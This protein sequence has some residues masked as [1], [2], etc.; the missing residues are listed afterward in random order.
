MTEKRKLYY[1][2][3]DARHDNTFVIVECG[4]VVFRGTLSE[5]RD[6]MDRMENEERTNER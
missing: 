1:D 2:T 3:D 4:D 6:E 5:C